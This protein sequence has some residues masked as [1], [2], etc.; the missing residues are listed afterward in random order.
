M[1]HIKSADFEDKRGG[2]GV[3]QRRIFP[4][5]QYNLSVYQL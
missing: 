1:P 4:Y 5:I 2:G 3:K